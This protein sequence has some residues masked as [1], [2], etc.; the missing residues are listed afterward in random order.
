MT[1]NNAS[2]RKKTRFTLRRLVIAAVGLFLLICAV[3]YVHGIHRVDPK[4]VQRLLDRNLK[5]GTD[6]ERVLQ[7]LDTQHIA[8]SEYLPELQRIYADIGRSSIGLATGRIN[9]VLTFDEQGKLVS[10]TV[11]ELFDFL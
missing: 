8:H 6:K 5:P 1:T 11:Q 9:I 10:Y 7:F 4:S 2:I 3:V